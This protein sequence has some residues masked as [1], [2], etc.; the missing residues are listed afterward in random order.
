VAGLLAATYD[1]R[2]QGI[3]PNL[4][5]ARKSYERAHKLGAPEAEERLPRSSCG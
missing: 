5:E 1:P 3:Q 4:A 2:A